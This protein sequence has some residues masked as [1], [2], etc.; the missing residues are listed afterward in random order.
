M[1]LATMLLISSD[2]TLVASVTETAGSIDGFGVEVVED[3]EAARPV[4]ER[5]DTV[6]VIYHLTERGTIKNVTWLLQTIVSDCPSI[7][8]MLV[9]D[10]HRPYEARD[11][12]RLGLADYQVR[13]LDLNRLGYMVEMLAVSARHECRGA[14]A[15]A[16]LAVASE[17]RREESRSPGDVVS[18][19]RTLEQV[20]RIA[21]HETTILL[22]GETGTG[23]TRLARNIHDLSPRRGKPFLVINCGALSASLIESEMFGH[24]RGAF[25][26]ADADRVGKFA[27]AGGGTLFLDEA[28]SL[29]MSVQPK[30]LRAVEE[31]VFEPVGS[32]RSQPMQARLIAASNRPLEQ[33]VAAGRF[34]ADLYY[35]LNVGSFVIPP[36]RQRAEMIPALAQEFLPEFAA[37]TGLEVNGIAPEALLC[38]LAHSWPGNIRELRNVIER[39]V[40]LCAG[41][42][43]QLDDLPPSLH[44]SSA[45]CHGLN[46]PV[47]EVPGGIP[48]MLPL[49]AAGTTSLARSKAAVESGVIAEA[50]QRNGG[51]RLKAAAELGISRKTLYQK[52]NKYGLTGTA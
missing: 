11:L 4:L 17:S 37:K 2:P 51:N 50:L 14:R 7:S 45:P 9:S 15:A 33:E 10:V 29:P 19:D 24:V 12:L 36:L 21:P 41:P 40:A 46:G 38:L 13:P 5:K 3:V 52:L 27:A 26:G 31:R 35:R 43:I 22:E 39:A 20:R 8:V 47:T 30:L 28:D 1:K 6:V 49:P 23:K 48:T 18:H 32:N 42:L 16:D 25:T 44:R 34:R